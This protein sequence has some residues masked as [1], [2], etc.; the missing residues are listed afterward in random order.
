VE[1]LEGDW[2]PNVIIIAGFPSMENARAW[3]NSV[4]YANALMVKPQAMDRN[5]V[6]TAG[7]P[8]N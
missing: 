3:Y 8:S 6:L 1:T 7:L 5:M 4:E 2:Q